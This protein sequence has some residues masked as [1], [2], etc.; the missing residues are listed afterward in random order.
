MNLISHLQT[1]LRKDSTEVHT[2]EACLPAVLSRRH[3]RRS[4][5]E[6]GSFNEVGSLECEGG[7]PEPLNPEL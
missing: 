6:D 7:T 4:F 5:S 2:P 3:V 1:C